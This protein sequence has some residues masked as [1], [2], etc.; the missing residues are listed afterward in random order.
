MVLNNIVDIK[1]SL[2][3]KQCINCIIASLIKNFKMSKKFFTTSHMI[4]IFY[5][6]L[7]DKQS[8][9]LALRKIEYEN[10]RKH[11]LPHFS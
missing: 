8:S 2:C 6:F 4:N 11:K 9:N 3:I 5:N 7:K 1:K 10:D